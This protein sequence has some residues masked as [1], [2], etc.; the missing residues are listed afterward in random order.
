MLAL[1][2][3]T[4]SAQQPRP[5]FSFMNTG[6]KVFKKRNKNTYHPKSK[7]FQKKGFK[8]NRKYRKPKRQRTCWAYSS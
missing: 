5:M 8:K 3:P 2:A 6:Q 7:L 4:V 1:A